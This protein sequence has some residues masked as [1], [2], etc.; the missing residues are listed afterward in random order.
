[1]DRDPDPLI[2]NTDRHSRMSCNNSDSLDSL[3][4]PIS[5]D[6]RSLFLILGRLE[7]FHILDDDVG[8]FY[9]NVGNDLGIHI[10]DGTLDSLLDSGVF[11]YSTADWTHEPD[12]LLVEVGSFTRTLLGDRLLVELKKRLVQP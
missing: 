12:G 9:E 4:T 6:E 5:F 2:A 11:E 1:M 10:E 8:T 3:L 7:S